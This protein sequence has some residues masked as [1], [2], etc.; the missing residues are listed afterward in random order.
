MFLVLCSLVSAVD[1][2]VS[3][4]PPLESTNISEIG[5]WT[6]V[7]AA[8]NMKRFVR[9]TPNIEDKVGFACLLV[10]TFTRDW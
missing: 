6:L 9:L 3:L 1:E 10:P 5:N 8:V 4:I 2:G 7:G